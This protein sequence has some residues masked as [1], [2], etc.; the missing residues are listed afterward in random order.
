MAEVIRR[1]TE[2][3][4]IMPDPPILSYDKKIDADKISGILADSYKKINSHLANRKLFMA[5]EELSNVESLMVENAM[6]Y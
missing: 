4:M 1:S 5:K 2:A 3:L 6:V